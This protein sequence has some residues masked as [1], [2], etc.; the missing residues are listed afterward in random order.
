[1]I[2]GYEVEKMSNEKSG[3]EFYIAMSKKLRGCVGQGA[4]TEEAIA[5]LEENERVWLETAKEFG[6]PIPAVPER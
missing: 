1:M 3:S 4:T 2:Y 5:E 6:V